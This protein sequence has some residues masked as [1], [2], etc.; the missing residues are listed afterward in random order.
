MNIRHSN[1]SFAFVTTFYYI[2]DALEHFS[3]HLLKVLKIA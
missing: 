1:I 2:I 3:G